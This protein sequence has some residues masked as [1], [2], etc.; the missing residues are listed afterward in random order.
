[1][2]DAKEVSPDGYNQGKVA[3][4]FI[5]QFNILM[6][7]QYKL[8]VRNPMKLGRSI[9]NSILMIII[10]G[11]IFL[12]TISDHHPNIDDVYLKF[13]LIYDFIIAQ[14]TSFVTVTSV[15]MTGI[16]SVALVFPVERQVYSK[17]IASKTYNTFPYFLSKLI[18]EVFTLI[19]SIILLAS[20]VYWMNGYSVDF[21]KFVKYGNYLCNLVLVLCSVGMV[22]NSIGFWTGSLFKDAQR[23]SAMSPALLMPL[24]MFSGLYN[25]LDS[26]PVWIRWMQYLS[27]FRFGLHAVL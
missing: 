25:K 13:N 2:E 3:N 10:L 7:R 1:M 8:F 5:D 20:G 23:S 11:V 15:I 6:L 19:F 21:E 4:T 26:I 22:G 9:G 24:M 17:E 16:F 14:G 27:P 12:Q 18:I